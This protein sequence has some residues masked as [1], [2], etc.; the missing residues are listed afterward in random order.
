MKSTTGQPVRGPNFFD[1]EPELDE[2][3]FLVERDHVLMLA[4]RRVGKTS[5][6]LRMQDRPREGWKVVFVDVEAVDSEAAF[7]AKLLAELYKLRPDGGLW[8]RLG[9]GIGN[10]FGRVGKV[11]VGATSLGLELTQAVG[12]DW[13]KVGDRMFRLLRDLECPCLVAIDE[14]PIFV[15]R[16]LG[17]DNGGDRTRL[18]LD[19]FRSL[20]I[21]T[22]IAEADVHFLLAG[23]IGL[24]AVV[25]RVAMSGTINDLRTFRLGELPDEQAD[26]LLVDLS[27]GESFDLP[28]PIRRRILELITWRI[29]YHLQLMFDQLLRSSRFE[30]RELGAALV[31]EAFEALLG[32]ESRKH[33]A[34]WEERIKDTLISPQER[35]LMKAL[36][37]AAARD[38][39]GF[40][41]DTAA[42]L[43]Q[44]HAPSEELAPVL[45]AL[46]HDGYLTRQ[47]DRWR[48]ASSL[49]RE[50]WRRWQIG[51]PA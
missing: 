10:V 6:L 4:P 5:L 47:N 18:L 29:P 7:V 25:N 11:E 2:L 39:K 42:Q 43:R 32:P 35:D 21:D 33:F 36:L 17:Q 24:D 46:E 38:P 20:R 41:D 48:F 45:L 37:A 34:H 14:F 9:E 16:L 8:S 49:L 44:Q 15:R 3:W 51:E 30:K 40:A 26:A 13:Q 31:D 23:S 1:R 28:E 50:W 27:R 22:E 12:D 19:W